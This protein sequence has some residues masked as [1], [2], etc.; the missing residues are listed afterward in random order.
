M[1]SCILLVAKLPFRQLYKV[2]VSAI[3]YTQRAGADFE[4]RITL[5]EGDY[6]LV[7]HSK[8]GSLGTKG[9]TREAGCHTIIITLEVTLEA[10]SKVTDEKEGN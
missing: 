4:R 8:G 3:Y 9:R 5:L 7:A 10:Q 1:S 6:H 2:I